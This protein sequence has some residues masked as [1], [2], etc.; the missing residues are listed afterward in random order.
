MQQVWMVSIQRVLS[1]G[2]LPA[3]H[4]NVCPGQSLSE[5]VR[6]CLAPHTLEGKVS[7]CVWHVL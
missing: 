5:N 3:A 6:F 1:L 7:Q 2:D 4:L